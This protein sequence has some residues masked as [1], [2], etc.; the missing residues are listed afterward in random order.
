MLL[1]L[2]HENGDFDAVASQL[3]TH[4][5]YPQG[6][7]ILPR[8]VNRNVHQF[9]ALYGGSFGFVRMEEWRRRKVE[10]IVL[11]D[12]QSVP[13]VRGVKPGVNVRVFDHHL[14]AETPPSWEIH[15]QPVGAT[16]TILVEMLQAA[17]LALSPEEATLLLLGIHEDT[18][19]LTYDTATMRDAQAA[20]W[21][22][23]HHA[24]LNIVRRFLEIPL[25]QEQQA[26]YAQLQL[27]AEWLTI[28]GQSILLATAKAPPRFDDEIS[29]VAHR[30]RDALVPDS[31]LVL[32]ELSQHVQLVA[33]SS[34]DQ[35]DVGALATALGGG[36]HSRAAAAMIMDAALDG[37]RQ[38]VLELLPQVIK[39][40]I[41]V[42][43]LMSHG[44]KTVTA[45]TSVTAA[46]DQMQRLGHEGYPVV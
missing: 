28:E 25:T 37:A 18:G 44:V 20:A 23:S 12:T 14:P 29:S 42:A 21:L 15:Y 36:G 35:V 45:S 33:R 19:S 9:L 39:P 16:T 10:D 1:I 8:R 7:P 4:K 5:L 32:V 46:A 30:M 6:V 26:L 41:K 43:Q 40:M 27:G 13:N 3:A 17:G 2:T 24:Q 31:L 38:Q 11:V 34:T 22:M